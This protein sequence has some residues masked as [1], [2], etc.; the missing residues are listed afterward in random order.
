MVG[1]GQDQDV[2]NARVLYFV[3]FGKSASVPKKMEATLLRG[4]K[5]A[6]LVGAVRT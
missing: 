6:L 3:V 4:R 2:A 5:N 1:L